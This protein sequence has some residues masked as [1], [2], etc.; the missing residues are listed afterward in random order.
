VSTADAAHEAGE[1]SLPALQQ[2]YFYLTEGC[3]CACRHCWLAPKLDPTAAKTAV[4]PLETFEAVIAEAK[5][6]G[7]DAIKLTG[8]EPL[9]HPQIL[10]L[11]R[12]VEREELRLSIETN[13]MCCTPAIAQAIARCN[14]PFV[15]V[16]VDGADADTHDYVRNLPGS[17]A[18]T[19]SG[20]DALKAAGI[21]PQIIMS[22]MRCNADQIDDLVHWAE[23]TGADSV[24]FNIVQPTARGRTLSSSA[25]GLEVEEYLEIGR[26]VELDLAQRVGLRLHYSYPMAFRPLSRLAEDGGCGTCGIKGLIGVIA[27]GHYALCGIGQHTPEL[28]F[29]LAGQDALETVWSQNEV[30]QHIRHQ[31]PERLQGICSQCVMRHRCLGSC[32]AQNYYRSRS[33]FA[34][35]W[36]C[37][38]AEQQGL[39][40]DSR[41]T[42]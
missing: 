37:E 15:A 20:I 41:K 27:T 12:V 33:L 34:P 4:L 22:V 11:L 9:M 23:A 6:L 1:E 16:S 36:F 35:F 25:D 13:A 24:K 10:D 2:I 38:L 8:G 21:A 7:L 18:R 40:P 26:Y 28:V 5:P 42:T 14:G 31:L 39:F 17:Y 30:L 19:L 29:G 3:N 32:V